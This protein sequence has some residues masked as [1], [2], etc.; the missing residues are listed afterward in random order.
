MIPWIRNVSKKEL[1][2][3]DS[4]DILIQIE[5]PGEQFAVA[6]RLYSQIIQLQFFGGKNNPKKDLDITD[7]QAKIIA[8]ILKLSLAEKKNVVVQC[9]SGLARSGAVAQVGI[10]M[11]FLDVGSERNPSKLVYDKISKTILY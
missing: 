1:N 7:Y 8:D 5:N 9:V 6:S 2:T 11:G 10:D 3:I 4:G